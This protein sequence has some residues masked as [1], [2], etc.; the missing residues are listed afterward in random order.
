M[1]QANGERVDLTALRGERATVL[2][3]LSVECPI[4]NGYLPALSRMAEEYAERGVRVVGLNPNNGQTLA[5]LAE[6]REEFS[7]EIPVLKDHGALAAE[8]LGVTTCPEVCLLDAVGRLRYRG[9][10]DDRYVRRG[11]G[12]KT[13]HQSDLVIALEQLL[14]GEEI[15]TPLTEAIGCPIARE[16]GTPPEE[17]GEVVFTRDIAPILQSRCQECH[18]PGGIGPF[19]LTNYDQARRWSE[20]LVYFTRERLMPPWKPVAGHGEFN[21]AR[22]MTEAEIA[23]I[24]AWVEAGCPRGPTAEL[25]PAPEFQNDWKRGEP[26]VILQ[27]T[28]EYTVAAEGSDD[29]RC[30][31]IPSVFE[32]DRFIEN[33]EILPGNTAV[34]HHVILFI[35]TTGKARELDAADPLPGYA[36][37][38]GF[39]GFLPSGA[40]GGWA[41]GNTRQPLPEGMAKI[42][43]AGADLVVQVHY[44]KT[45]KRETDR[46]R[47]GLH[48]CEGKVERLVRPLAVSP[49]PFLLN[50]PPGESNQQ[51]TA[52][53]TLPDDVLLVSIT[54]HMHLLGKDM[55]V[56]AT[57]PNGSTQ[58]LL[59]V[60]NWDFNWQESYQ[61]RK[62]LE[63][64]QGTRIDLEAHFDNSEGNP[65]NPNRPPQWVRWGEETNDEM[66]LA[67]LE[68]AP[69][70][71]VRDASELREMTPRERLAWNL[72]ARGM[73]GDSPSAILKRK[74]ME[75]FFRSRFG[76]AGP[77]AGE[78][79]AP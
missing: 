65:Y 20:D 12:S 40:L 29:Y 42:M 75:Q 34:V 49:L 57:L 68:L 43:P 33:F 72:A 19:S 10:I 71:A 32:K 38:G 13:I 74:L 1:T 66:C 5:Q 46:T 73:A 15:A 48:F 77:L 18:R 2:V 6:H 47:I 54:P 69:V 79:P 25:P 9:R 50:L 24:A 28:E 44:H 7:V 21:G 11:G 70:A 52:S 36:S 59:L 76:D 16:P 61:Y 23:S 14:A 37:L 56:W 78:K 39:P 63:L 4:S 55:R 17:G 27:P 3:F 35:D 58:R 67:F 64:P 51:V 30:F 8:K 31:V 62:P 53:I 41:P 45:G 26:D 22:V 60:R